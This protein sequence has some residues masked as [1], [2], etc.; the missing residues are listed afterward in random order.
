MNLYRGCQHR[1]I[2]CDSRSLCYEIADFDHEILVKENA[3]T[4][5][6]EEL[7][8]KRKPGVLGTGSMN[9]PYMP[10]E[11][12]LGMTRRAL[13]VIAEFGFGVHVQNEKRSRPARSRSPP[14]HCAREG[15]GLADGH[16]DRR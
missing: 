15:L 3:I 7:S 8:R 6:R 1:C 9:D 14:A 4:Q 10:I 11:E 16:H 12:S 2:Y 5:L 13:E